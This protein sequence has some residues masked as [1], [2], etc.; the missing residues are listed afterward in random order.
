MEYSVEAVKPLGCGDTLLVLDY[1]LPCDELKK[2]RRPGQLLVII[3]HHRAPP[4]ESREPG[5]LYCNPVSM[6]AGGEDEWPATS[7][8]LYRITGKYPDLALLGVLGD[9]PDAT[10]NLR[11]LV[12]ELSEASGVEPSTAKLAAEMLDSC[13]RRLDYACIE[14]SVGLL[15]ASGISGVLGDERLRRSMREV[16]EELRAALDNTR[17][18]EVE[19]SGVLYCETELNNPLHTLIGRRLACR[20][21]GSIV[22]LVARV[23]KLNDTIIYVR[24]VTRSPGKLLDKARAL[25]KA[26][27]PWASIG[28]KERVFAVEKLGG[29]RV[30]RVVSRLLRLLAEEA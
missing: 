10:S 11:S 25:V 17:C 8:L 4:P 29:C 6:G 7:L 16:E 24:S 15:A 9:R 28:G 27:C 21:K 13:Y 18:R 12:D 19:D 23:K 1:G 26:E 2:L 14:R 20:N 3:D 22:V 30:D 5:V